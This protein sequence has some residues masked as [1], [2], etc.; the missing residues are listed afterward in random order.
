MQKNKLTAVIWKYQF[1]SQLMMPEGA[2][3]LSAQEQAGVVMIWVQVNPDAPKTIRRFR[4]LATGDPF[5]PTG[6]VPIGTVLRDDG[7]DVA[8]IY[9]DTSSK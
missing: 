4:S 1:S 7:L 6:L 5:D 9:E 3:I 2:I 8:H